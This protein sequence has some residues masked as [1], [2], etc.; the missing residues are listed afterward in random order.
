MNSPI[1]YPEKKLKFV[2]TSPIR[3]DGVPKVT[4]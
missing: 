2:G 3:P 1:R 4:C